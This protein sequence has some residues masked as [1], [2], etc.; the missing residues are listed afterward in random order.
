MSKNISYFGGKG[1]N[2]TYQNIINEIPKCNIYVECMVGGGSIFKNLELPDITVI[3]DID[4][5]V[6]E[7]YNCIG[8]GND[9]RV[10]NEDYRKVCNLYDGSDTV[11]YFDPP[12]HFDTRKSKQKRYFLEWDTMDHIA[13]LDYV[14]SLKSKIIIS[15]YP[16]FLYDNY[17]QSWR[18]KEF[19][20]MTRKG[21]VLEKIYMNFDTPLLLQDYRYIGDNFIDRQRIKRQNQRILNKISS[22]PHHQKNLLYKQISMLQ[23]D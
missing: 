14:S 10:Y 21:Q 7:K 4:P 1:G 12:Y 8:H 17:L 6:I 23:R 19:L 22:L 18:T 5:G 2:G 15:H 11:I 20:S 9:I 3:N 16:F 13:F